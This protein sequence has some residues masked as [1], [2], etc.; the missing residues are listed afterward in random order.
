MM[1]EEVTFKETKVYKFGEI[2]MGLDKEELENS[3][4]NEIKVMFSELAELV[5]D[6]YSENKSPVKSLLFD[7]AIYQIINA[8]LAINK[9]LKTK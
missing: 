3:L 6:S 5:K 4:E 9:L 7:H 1:E 8:E 2:L